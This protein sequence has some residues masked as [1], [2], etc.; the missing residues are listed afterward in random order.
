M[1]LSIVPKSTN[2]YRRETF[3]KSSKNML[4]T[5]TPRAPK[6]EVHQLTGSTNMTENASEQTYALPSAVKKP[7]PKMTMTNTN[8]TFVKSSK[9]M[10][11]RA[12][13]LTENTRGQT[14]TNLGRRSIDPTKPKAI[15]TNM[16][17]KRRSVASSS[18]P[19]SR[20]T[21]IKPTKST[22]LYIF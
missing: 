16:K 14:N 10:V 8:E 17:A 5:S 15:Q 11:V 18:G 13:N 19:S 9:N 22:G 2:I 21:L 3:I 7:S 4:I 1:E 6:P 20:L 12:P